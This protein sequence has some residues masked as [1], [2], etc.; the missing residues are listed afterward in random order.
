M[1]PDEEDLG[2]GDLPTPLDPNPGEVIFDPKAVNF[3]EMFNLVKGFFPQA[4]VDPPKVVHEPKVT[5]GVFGREEDCHRNHVALSNLASSERLRK[6]LLINSVK[7]LGKL[8]KV[9]SFSLMIK[10]FTSLPSP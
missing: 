9:I 4:F 1:D 5:E 3:R 10:W 6:R 7:E 2:D 8:R